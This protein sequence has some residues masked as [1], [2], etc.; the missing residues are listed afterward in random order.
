MGGGLAVEMEL[1]VVDGKIQF[2]EL[3]AQKPS[4]FS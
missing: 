3:Q 4:H 1:L 2:P